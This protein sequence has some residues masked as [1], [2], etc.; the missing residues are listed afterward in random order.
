MKQLENQVSKDPSITSGS[1]FVNEDTDKQKAYNDA[2]QAAKD[3]INQTSNPTL[4]KTKGRR[5][6]TKIQNAVNDLHGEQN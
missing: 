2:V 6:T 5:S 4:D 3:L 1:P